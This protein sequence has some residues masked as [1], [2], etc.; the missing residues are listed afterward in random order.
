MKQNL[1]IYF[2]SFFVFVSSLYIYVF[3]EEY[4]ETYSI[5]RK[6]MF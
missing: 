1:G 4:I 5:L 6:L 2:L 3:N